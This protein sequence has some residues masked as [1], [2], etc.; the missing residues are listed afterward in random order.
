LQNDASIGIVNSRQVE[1]TRHIPCANNPDFQ[2]LNRL[3]CSSL[4]SASILTLAVR[5]GLRRL[6]HPQAGIMLRSAA[7][8]GKARQKALTVANY[9]RPFAI[10][11]KVSGSSV[12]A[13]EVQA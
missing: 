13:V 7:K 11:L 6:C 1:F 5:E 10:C 3:L 12:I 8:S 2:H 4:Y 9:E